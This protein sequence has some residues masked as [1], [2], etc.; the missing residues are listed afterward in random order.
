MW[1]KILSFADYI[2][3]YTGNHGGPRTGYNSHMALL[4]PEGNTFG[5]DPFFQPL[6]C[7]E[8]P[9]PAGLRPAVWHDKLIV[10]CHGVDMHGPSLD[11][12]G[13]AQ[14][15]PQILGEHGRIEAVLCPVGDAERLLLRLN[16]EDRQARG[17]NDSVA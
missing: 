6:I 9:E 8:A 2:T 4:V 7:V 15:P 16:L 13:H 11:L 12:L 3:R 5:P 14:A 1:Y 10:Q 17:P